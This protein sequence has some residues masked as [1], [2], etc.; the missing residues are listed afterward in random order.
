MLFD[1]GAWPEQKGQVKINYNSW[2]GHWKFLLRSGEAVFLVWIPNSQIG[3]TFP[4]ALQDQ[5]H[6]MQM[7]YGGEQLAVFKIGISQ[8]LET[9]VCYYYEANYSEMRCIHATNSLA[10]VEMLEA[11]LIHVFKES[12]PVQCRNTL[13]GGEGMRN[14]C[15]KPKNPPPYFVY[16][17]AA[18]ASQRKSIR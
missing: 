5:I 4:L 8:C 13:G 1:D 3:F 16:V 9:R 2:L 7:K 18:N 14:K 15:G 17:V 10:Q 6:K 11:S 12:F